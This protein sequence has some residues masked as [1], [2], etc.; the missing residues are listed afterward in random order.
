MGYYYT[1]TLTP[2]AHKLFSIVFPWGKHSYLRLP[3]GIANEPNIFHSK[4]NQ[5]MDGLDYTTLQRLHEA[6]L[7][8]YMEKRTFATNDVRILWGPYYVEARQRLKLP[9][10][11]KQLRS[12]LGL[13]YYYRE[14]WKR[15]NKSPKGNKLFN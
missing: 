2:K 5:L 11:L 6:N 10:T 14:M 13:V 12:L 9:K 3:M 4:I 1:L 7:K 15:F 8:F